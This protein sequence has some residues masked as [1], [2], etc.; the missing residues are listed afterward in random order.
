MECPFVRILSSLASSIALYWR[1][2][3]RLQRRVVRRAEHPLLRCR[4]G[5]EAKALVKTVGVSGAQDETDALHVWDI[6][7]RLHH[8]NAE[9][10][11]S[12]RFVDDDVGH[13]G[14][15]CVIGDEAGERNLRSVGL[16][17]GANT[18]GV[19]DRPPNHLTTAPSAQ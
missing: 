13:P 11:A 15:G 10:L 7:R 17:I 1:R 14:E 16:A 3:V 4:Q 6:D 18:A 19:L 12:T 5:L 8:G 9:A 2:S